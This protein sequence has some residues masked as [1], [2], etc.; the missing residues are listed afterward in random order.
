MVRPK[1]A[2]VS[3]T[4]AARVQRGNSDGIA[5]SQ[6]WLQSRR[7][8]TSAGGVHEANDSCE[9]CNQWQWCGALVQDRENLIDLGDGTP[10]MPN[11]AVAC[12]ELLIPSLPRE[13]FN[14]G[15]TPMS[16]HSCTPPNLQKAR[17][18]DGRKSSGC[19]THLRCT[20]RCTPRR[21]PPRL[22]R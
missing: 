21:F 13:R 4:G 14:L 5:D 7:Q 15:K 9:S 19:H 2:C 12:L 8:E 6:G 20:R 22:Y 3:R 1:Q 18:N 16:P 17:K 10:P 11:R